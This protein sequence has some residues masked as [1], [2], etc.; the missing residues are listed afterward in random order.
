MN[1]TDTPLPLEERIAKRSY[2]FSRRLFYAAQ[3]SG[4]AKCL[5]MEAAGELRVFGAVPEEVAKRLLRN[6]LDHYLGPW[7]EA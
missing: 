1:D 6:T 3:L 2:A 4:F 7:A 5:Q